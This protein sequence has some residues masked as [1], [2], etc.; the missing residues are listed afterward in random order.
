MHAYT[1]DPG[2]FLT[3][4]PG[5]RAAWRSLPAPPILHAGEH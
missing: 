3:K 5:S 1:T 4:L 2:K